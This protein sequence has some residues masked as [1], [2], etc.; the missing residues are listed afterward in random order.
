MDV[1]E[2]LFWS[3]A[4]AVHNE[5]TQFGQ[6]FCAVALVSCGVVSIAVL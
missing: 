2:V 4:V 3:T 6:M 1:F 5:N